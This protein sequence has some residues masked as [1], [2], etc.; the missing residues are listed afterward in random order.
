MKQLMLKSLSIFF[1]LVWTVPILGQAPVL[2]YEDYNLDLDG[3]SLVIGNGANGIPTV[4]EAGEDMIWDYSNFIGEDV[5]DVQPW[6][7]FETCLAGPARLADQSI[8]AIGNQVRWLYE[9]SE[10]G[11]RS[12]TMD[13]VGQFIFLGNGGGL[14]WRDTCQQFPEDQFWLPFPVTYQDAWE[15]DI[16]EKRP[17]AIEI[18]AIIEAT[19]AYVE[20]RTVALDSVSGWGTV[21]IPGA[22]GSLSFEVL[23]ME[24]IVF[25]QDSLFQDGQPAS[26][27]LINILN[28]NQGRNSLVRT[29]TL[30]SNQNEILFVMATDFFGNHLYHAY[31][32]NPDLPNTTTTIETNTIKLYPNPTSERTIYLDCQSCENQE[33]NIH[34]LNSLGQILNR[35]S[36]VFNETQ[37]IILPYNSPSGFY[38]LALFTTDQRLVA[39]LPFVLE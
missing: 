33:L 1:L 34:L 5:V 36:L 7:E 23:L 19:E 28:F 12:T 22:N 3:I 38:Y 9:V 31:L 2:N 8:G 13:Q 37:N 10:T 27:S 18:P 29:Y 14:L 30:R 21:I 39:K 16:V 4:P 11:I 6:S 25:Q 26:D 17:F 20:R 24:Q 15:R 32:A 35:Q